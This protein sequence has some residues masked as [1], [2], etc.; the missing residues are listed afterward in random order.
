MMTDG[1]ASMRL[2]GPGMSDRGLS[3]PGMLTNNIMA[4]S[5]MEI[6]KPPIRGDKATIS[7]F[8]QSKHPGTQ[9]QMLI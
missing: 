9:S 6:G 4:Q 5:A 2:L 3:Y 7:R 8:K 1:K